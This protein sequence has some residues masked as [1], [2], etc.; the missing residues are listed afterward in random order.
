MLHH[1][2]YKE[3]TILLVI[4][5]TLYALPCTLWK[6]LTYVLPAALS[7]NINMYLHNI[8]IIKYV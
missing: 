3:C 8:C 6:N 7:I 5:S 2:I 4:F 1:I